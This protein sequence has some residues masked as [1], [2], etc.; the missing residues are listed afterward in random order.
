MVD[1]RSLYH[2]VQAAD[3]LPNKIGK[4]FW[5]NSYWKLNF[6]SYDI[7]LILLTLW[8]FA[9]FSIKCPEIVVSVS[10]ISKSMW[11]ISP[12]YVNICI[13]EFSASELIKH[14]AWH[15]LGLWEALNKEWL[16]WQMFFPSIFNIIYVF[17]W[18]FFWAIFQLQNLLISLW[19]RYMRLG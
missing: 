7:N 2:L 13:F 6:Y 3:Y 14:A 18:N 1:G 10:G 16:W 12:P 8:L 15:S 17:K 5:L 4:P 19:G 11:W 9:G